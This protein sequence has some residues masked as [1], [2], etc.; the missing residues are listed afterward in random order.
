MSTVIK[1][2]TIVTADLTYKADV[3]IE[4]GRI[5]QIGDGLSGDEV[6]DVQVD[7]VVVGADAAALA[8]ARATAG[9]DTERLE[10]YVTR[11]SKV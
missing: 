1:N 7:V 4:D 11:Q 5:S 9:F 8:F 3:L 2:G 6:L 10:D